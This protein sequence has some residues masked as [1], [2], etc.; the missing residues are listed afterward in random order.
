MS[1]SADLIRHPATDCDPIRRIGVEM[2]RAREGLAL[3]YRIEGEVARLSLPEA[4]PPQRADGLWQHS[5]F[6]A[7][8][9]ADGGDSYLEFNFSPSGAWAAYRFSGRRRGRESP[10]L[11]APRTEVRRGP[12]WLAMNIQLSLAGIAH[13]AGA[14]PILAGLAAV[15]EDERGGLSYWALVHG[16]PQPDFHDPATFTLRV[17]A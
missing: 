14:V 17:P 3:S 10:E 13:F 6:E 1:A 15:I 9:L 7:F 11:L 8:L 2:S 4:G 12:D 16:A 5:C